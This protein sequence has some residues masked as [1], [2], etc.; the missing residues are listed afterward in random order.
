MQN[1]NMFTA[2]EKEGGGTERETANEI[3]KAVQPQLR[4][5]LPLWNGCA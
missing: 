1:Q 2:R 5:E 4:L 3:G